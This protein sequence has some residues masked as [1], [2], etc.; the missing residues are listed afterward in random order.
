M[1]F[2]SFLF[3]MTLGAIAGILFA[4]DSGRRSRALI[5][6][7]AIKYGKDTQHFVDRKSKHMANKMRGYAHD[8]KEVVSKVSRHTEEEVEE[9]VAAE[10]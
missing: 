6:D 5:R 2:R 1:R 4:P 7:K 10:T 3:A 9:E 8:V